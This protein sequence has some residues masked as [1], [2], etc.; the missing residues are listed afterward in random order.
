[1][2]TDMDRLVIFHRE[3]CFY[4]IAIPPMS[5]TGVSFDQM[6]K[7]NVELNP[8]TLEVT[9]AITGEQLWAATV[10]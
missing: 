2:I 7:D 6:I 5:V 9:D 3:P 8:G 4:P 1:M 10:N